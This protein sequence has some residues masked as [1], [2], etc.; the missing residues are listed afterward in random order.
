M[1]IWSFKK[2]IDSDRTRTCNLQIRSLAPYPLGHTVWYFTGDFQPT[3]FFCIQPCCNPLLGHTVSH[4]LL[5]STPKLLI[6]H[7][8]QCCN[9]EV[10]LWYRT[11]GTQ[12]K[13]FQCEV[14]RQFSCFSPQKIVWP[15]QDCNLHPP[16]QESNLQSPA[17]WALH[18]PMPHRV[19]NHWATRPLS[20]TCIFFKILERKPSDFIATW[21][22]TIYTSPISVVFCMIT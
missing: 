14:L 3:Y 10:G 1:D 20:Y 19:L 13:H 2:G 5:N 11:N 15:C 7:I 4:W 8:N 22:A 21:L 9:V 17:S 18:P 16:W 12:G 6:L